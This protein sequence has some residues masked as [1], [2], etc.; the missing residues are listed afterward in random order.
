MLPHR[1]G[2]GLL[3]RREVVWHPLE[4][5]LLP[6]SPSAVSALTYRRP[7]PP[8]FARGGEKPTGR[9]PGTY[10]MCHCITE[11]ERRTTRWRPRIHAER[12]VT[13]GALI[14]PEG[15]VVQAEV[16]MSRGLPSR[17]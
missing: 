10:S 5:L 1:T 16:D 3:R 6:P 2:S 14:G 9:L 15:A 7:V 11:P 8:I 13:G 12:T 17:S 4:I